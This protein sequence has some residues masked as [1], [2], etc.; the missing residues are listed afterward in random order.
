MSKVYYRDLMD[1]ARKGLNQLSNNLEAWQ[2]EM[3]NNKEFYI[4]HSK[5]NESES[6]FWMLVR[7]MPE[8]DVPW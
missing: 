1:V 7:E 6:L 8:Q 3:K 5:A 4:Q 2:S